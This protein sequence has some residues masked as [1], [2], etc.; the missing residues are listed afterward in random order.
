MSKKWEL[1]DEEIEE[2]YLTKFPWVKAGQ[3]VIANTAL[4][5]LVEWMKSYPSFYHFHEEGFTPYYGIRFTERDWDA[6]C[7]ELGVK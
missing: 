3:R 4:K 2:A 5:K 7:K 6:L 1:T